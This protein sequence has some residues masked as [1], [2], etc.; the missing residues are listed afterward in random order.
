MSE[1]AN[2]AN[3]VY[4]YPHADLTDRVECHCNP[5]LVGFN[6]W[7]HVGLTQWCGQHRPRSAPY[8][9][10]ADNSPAPAKSVEQR[11]E[12]VKRVVKPVKRNIKQ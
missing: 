2:C 11:G 6:G 10:P 12:P 1:Q 3:C 7:A 8:R 9:A 4:S 5:P